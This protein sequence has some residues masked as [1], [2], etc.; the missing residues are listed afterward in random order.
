MRTLKMFLLFLLFLL[1]Y[2]L[3][4]GKNGIFDFVKI[5][6]KVIIEKKNNKYL[7][8]RNH[9]ILLEIED[10]NNHIKKKKNS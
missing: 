6:N 8:I 1:Q 2:S 7:D 5:Y 3:W 4:C 9:Q 10:L